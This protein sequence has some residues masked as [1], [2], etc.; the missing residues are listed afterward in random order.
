MLLFRKKQE[1][2]ELYTKKQEMK[3]HEKELTEGND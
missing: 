1:H 2:K 3:L